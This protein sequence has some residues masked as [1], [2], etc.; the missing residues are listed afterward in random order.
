M[1]LVIRYNL[2]EAQA[3]VIVSEERMKKNTIII[4]T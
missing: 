2:Q 4:H 3:L 1:F